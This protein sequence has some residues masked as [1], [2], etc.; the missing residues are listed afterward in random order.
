MLTV[1]TIR[2]IR[3]AIHRDGK[4][5]RG[6]AKDL[7]LSRNTVR[8]VIRS[9][10]TAFQ[11]KRRAQPHPKLGEHITILEER[12]TE[13]QAL[14]KKQRRTAQMLYEQL[15][16]EGY[17]GGYDTVRRYVKRWRQ[18]NK[19][20]GAQVFIPLEFEPGEA[21]QFDWSHESV[22]MDG[23]PTKVKVAHI[24]LCHSRMFLVVAYPRETQEMVFD[25]H[26]RAFDHFG[27]VCR[28]G[29]YDNLKAVV[30]KILTG[31][32]RNFNSRFAQLCSHYLFEPVACTPASG[33]EKGQVENQ[34]GVVRRR[35]FT[36]RLK[37]KDFNQLNT[38]LLERCLT[39]AKTQKHPNMSD[40]TIWDVY[41]AERACMIKLPPRFDGYAERPARVSPSS[42][43]T[44][45][46]NR[47]SVNCGEVGRVVQLRVYADRIVIV[48]NNE[49][50]GEHPRQF[51]RNKTVFDPWHY[52]PALGRKPGALRN[53]A[54][55]KDWDLPVAIRRVQRR[56][57][58]LYADWDHQFVGILKTVP[59][60][61]LEAVDGAC[62][63]ALK[64]P[65][66]SKEVVLNILHRSQDKEPAMVIELPERLMLK[67]EP[68][69]DCQRYEKLMDRRQHAAK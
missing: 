7:C 43:V 25:A 2:K 36:P 47:Y 51:G 61:G 35:F 50:A 9:D 15:Q 6:T 40:Q 11:Y 29:I 41:E 8:K 32:E 27:G 16:L 31:K 19:R 68:V 37:V 1:E 63:Q 45:D 54:P 69:A 28:R 18:D 62:Q 3:L 44:Y 33:W 67:N 58:R 48:S 5:I 13:D 55:F 26:I 10:Q 21:F 53:G 66:V 39:W 60:C 34:V 46:R 24:R 38:Y 22:Q 30:N 42:L 56:L 65:V 17:T 23:M 4:S 59:I 57:Q 64:L 52:L 12:L 14:H 20:S 49:V